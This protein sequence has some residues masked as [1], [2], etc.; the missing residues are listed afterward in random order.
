MVFNDPYYILRGIEEIEEI[1][2]RQLVADDGLD[3]ILKKSLGL[4][5]C[6]RAWLSYPCDPD[7]P[8]FDVPYERTTAQ[9][10]GTGAL[11]STIPMTPSL[12]SCCRQALAEIG[13]PQVDLP[14][15]P[16]KNND[17][18]LKFDVKSQVF[19][20]LAPQ[21]DAPW[22]FGIH[23]CAAAHHW[24]DDDIYLFNS[25]GRTITRFIEKL[26][27]I[28]QEAENRQKYDKLFETVSD[29]AYLIS[30]TGRIV[31]VN[32][33]ACM[34][35]NRKKEEI[36]ELYIDDVDQKFSAQAFP[37]FLDKV[38]FNTPNRFESIH[39][40]KND[41][42]ISVEVI[43]QK[44]RIEKTTYYFYIAKNITKR[45]KAQKALK[46]SEERF[47]NLME[48]VDAVAVQGYGPDGTTQ[49]WN[50]ASERLYGYTKQEAIGRNLLD[51]IIPPELIDFVTGGIRE[52]AKSGR[53][54]P[55][56]ELLL[57]HK[58]GSRVPVISHHA[59]VK[60]PGRKQELFCVDI[61]ISERKH[62]QKE[63]E[64]LK[65]QLN[66]A[67]KMEAIGRLA[68]GVAHDFNNM[69][70]V[71][72]GYVELAFERTEP[73]QDQHSELLEI[74][75]A[76]Q[77][78]AD[79]TKQL[80]TFARKQIISP[81]VIDLNVTVESMLKMLRRII[82][83]NIDLS[84]LPADC[85]WPVRIDPTQIDQIL[86]N[87]C[88]NARDA[89]TGVGKLTIET[90]NKNFDQAYCDTH[91]GFIPGDYVMLAVT[92]NGCG[93]DK[94]TIDNLFEPFFTTKAIGKGT[95]LGLATVYG[96]V[97][98]NDGFIKVYTRMGRGSTFKIYLR[99]FHTSGQPRK[100]NPAVKPGL[101]GNETI[102]L[103][104]DE[105]AILKMTKMMLNRQGY[106]VLSAA[107]PAD[108]I[109]T[110]GTYAQKIHLLLTDVVMPE[111]NGRDLAKKVIP[112]APGI[113]TLFMS[114][115]A[116]NV[117]T[118]Q[119]VADDRTAFIQKPFSIHELAEKIR[120]VLDN[121]PG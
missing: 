113:K 61:D 4:F 30:E 20:A 83:E 100:K 9:F 21:N 15:V 3:Q 18:A 1:I 91:A 26:T 90:Q 102:L 111:M 41:H 35:L 86:A 47:R 22:M 98:Q 70:G 77:R 92:D 104:E 117:I 118:R 50:K 32:Q 12:S 46:E 65:E 43:G 16:P 19:M 75:K 55:S 42:L 106:S 63:Q 52:M 95:G 82:G 81:E 72:L 53:P 112:L 71:I 73:G 58:N 88:V 84:W 5:S 105:P 80:L 78:S 67:R 116:D 115:H 96:I 40:T 101:A 114:G 107:T 66:H 27:F 54:V 93:M 23:H 121:T 85:L 7:L 48:N 11:N 6:D 109:S 31:D 120:G 39:K 60:L 25:I 34:C 14:C 62:A 10:P 59:I 103:V 8:E 24:T 64:K 68:G 108:A 69:L 37:A 51:L 13:T 49:Y 56:G 79:L 119:G 97:K 57:M 29:A 74:Q 28:R 89:I 87:L 38:P 36:L 44:F 94:E 45:Q 2:N 17:I 99:R 110:A 33:S 76:A